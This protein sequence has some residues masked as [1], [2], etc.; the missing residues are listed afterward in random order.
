MESEEEKYWTVTMKV[1]AFD[2]KENAQAYAEKL[3]DAFCDMPESEEYCSV[4]SVVEAA[5]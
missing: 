5:Q 4:C 1:F 2:T 3:T